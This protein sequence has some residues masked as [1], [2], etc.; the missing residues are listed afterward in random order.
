MHERV[1]EKY[2]VY[3]FQHPLEV[4]SELTADASEVLSLLEE[5]VVCRLH[6]GPPGSH[7]AATLQWEGGAAATSDTPH[8]P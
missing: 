1:R 7:D 6:R 4:N 2:L 3:L 5:G 8:T